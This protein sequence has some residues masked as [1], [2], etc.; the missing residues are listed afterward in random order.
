MITSLKSKT[1]LKK[2]LLPLLAAAPFA[3]V[4]DAQT[5]QRSTYSAGS[6]SFGH[7]VMNSDVGDDR[8]VYHEDVNGDG[9]TDVVITGYTPTSRP[10]AGAQPGQILLNNGNNTFRAAT[11]DRPQTEWA[12][13]VLVADFNNDNIPDIFIADHGWDAHPFPGFRNQLLLGT[14]QGFTDATDRL[15][16]LSDFSHNAA[17]GDI[18]GD[19]FIDI[20]VT[21]PPQGNAAKAP[22]LLINR[23]NARFDLDRARLPASFVRVDNGEYAWAVELA[24]LD[25][26]GR[27]DMIIGRKQGLTTLP[28][29]IYW[30]PGNGDFSNAAV[31]HLP[32][33]RRFVSGDKY[34]IIEIKAYDVNRNGRLDLMMTAYN[35]SFRGTGIQLLSNAGN[36]QFVDSTDVC[37]SGVTQDPDN[38]RG[39]PFHLRQV[40]VNFDGVQDFVAIKNDDPSAQTTLFFEG[41][42]GGR[43]RALNRAN[44]GGDASARER[45]Q[46]GQPLVGNGVFGY[47]EIFTLV[48][49]GQRKLGLNYV[50]VTSTANTPVANRFDVCSNLMTSLVDAGEL[51]RIQL[52]FRLLR[53]EPTVR[54]QALPESI[55]SISALPAKSATFNA[56]SGLL[57][58][59]E[60][61]LDDAIGYSGLRFQLIDGDKLIFE[62]VGAN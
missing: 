57:Q 47:A 7:F 58:I 61:V 60:L 27:A 48:E 55:K 45:L 21:N 8:F 37:L 46:V 20:L 35:S 44:L 56:T 42:G 5:A 9:Y 59:P 49:N 54:I 41:S 53:M 51:G 52:N 25:N 40:D 4:V 24:D 29:R 43:L 28:S 23:G 38:V 15:P 36:R 31:T 62:L 19:G 2:L 3:S 32:D 22:Y 14:G 1:Y 10:A 6:V 17:V 13:E 18:N 26:D 34:E 39:T 12:R 50:P 30:N 16:V 11:G 33:M